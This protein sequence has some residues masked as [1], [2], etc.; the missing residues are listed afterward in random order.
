MK[1]RCSPKSSSSSHYCHV[2][3]AHKKE[4][5]NNESRDEAGV[6]RQKRQNGF[7]DRRHTL[8]LNA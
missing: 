3:H 1:K 5:D 7:S 2:I 6:R 8:T 4:Q